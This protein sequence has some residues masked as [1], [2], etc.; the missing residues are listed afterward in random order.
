MDF[1]NHSSGSPVAARSAGDCLNLRGDPLHIGDE[2][3]VGIGAGVSCVKAVDITHEHQHIGVGQLCH[4]GGKGIVV[5]EL[6]LFHRYGI[7]LVDDGDGAQFHQLLEGV[8]N[9]AAAFLG[10]NHIA[11]HQYLGYGMVIF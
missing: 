7:V 10:I 4:D 5:A 8:D 1:C 9:P 2:F 11:G 6:N 3:G